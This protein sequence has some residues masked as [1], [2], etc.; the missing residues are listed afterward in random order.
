TETETENENAQDDDRK[1]KEKIDKAKKKKKKTT[2]QSKTTKSGSKSNKKKNK[3]MVHSLPGT[4]EKKNSLEVLKDQLQKIDADND[5]KI[6][7][8]E[9]FSVCEHFRLDIS[10]AEAKQIYQHSQQLT[11]DF[12]MLLCDFIDHIKEEYL[13]FP[14]LSPS[15]LLK[16]LF[17][18]TIQESSPMDRFNQILLDN[19]V[20]RNDFELRTSLKMKGGIDNDHNRSISMPQMYNPRSLISPSSFLEGS[21]RP[22]RSESIH[23]VV[24]PSFI[25]L[26]H[27]TNMYN[28]PMAD[29]HEFT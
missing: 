14:E 13:S 5:G 8:D 16:R 3:K 9:F 23:S 1:K 2:K 15:G 24:S 27:S 26:P 25:T 20:S 17:A 21:P 6:T 10:K 19:I 29:L 12:Q 7:F 11:T 4:T 18:K 22:E 28:H